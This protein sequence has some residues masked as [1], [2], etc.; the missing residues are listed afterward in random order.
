MRPTG[1][2]KWQGGLVFVSE[3]LRG[4]L[5]GLVET[6]RGDWTVRFLQVELGRI[7]RQ[8]RRFTPGWH[9]RRVA[10]THS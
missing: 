4:E 7:G 8:T 1:Q 3:A 2:I 5:V 9:G 10:P 6:P